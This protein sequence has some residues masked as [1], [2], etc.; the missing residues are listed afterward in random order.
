MKSSNKIALLILWTASIVFGAFYITLTFNIRLPGDDLMLLYDYTKDGW[1]DSVIN[2]RSNVRWTS[3]L[4]CNTVFLPNKNLATIHWNIA[5]FYF[6][7]FSSLILAFTFFIRTIFLRFNNSSLALKDCVLVAFLFCLTLF[8][9]TT[10]QC[11]VWFWM[12]ATTI[13]LVPILFFVLGFG[14]LFSFKNNFF[15]YLIITISFLYIGGAVETFALI[16][17]FLLSGLLIITFLKSNH[18]E[19]ATLRNKILVAIASLVVFLFKNLMGS[20]IIDRFHS[21]Q[22]LYFESKNSIKHDQATKI[23]KIFEDPANL[24]IVLCILITVIIGTIYRDKGLQLSKGKIKRM[25]IISGLLL[26]IISGITFIPLY[27]T[28]NNLGPERAWFPFNFFL[29]LFLF[30]LAFYIGNVYE[31]KLLNLTPSK[32]II[33][34][35]III[36]IGILLKNQYPI[37]TNYSYQYDQRIERLIKL[38]KIGNTKPAYFK[39]MPNSGLVIKAELD[40]NGLGKESN[41]FKHLLNLNFEVLLDN[42]EKEDKLP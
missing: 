25:V 17:L 21:I 38:K 22:R 41:Y 12:S 15:T 39:P 6:F 10:A 1:L 5:I 34:S 20:K 40:E 13:Y 29:T 4:L 32:Y 14:H 11:E 18:F 31:F 27:F 42:S 23:I 26:V 2:F 16:T 28:F 33:A 9:C 7:L 8:Y 37:V 3:I 35:F 19:L 36:K 30:S 24:M